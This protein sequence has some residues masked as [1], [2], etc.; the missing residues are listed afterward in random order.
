MSF[1]SSLDL[2]YPGKPPVVTLGQLKAFALEL[3][4]AMPVMHL[5]N[6]SLKYGRAI[7]KDLKPIQ[8]GTRNAAG[9]LY[10]EA[11][12]WNYEKESSHSSLEADAPFE[13]LWPPTEGSPDT[14]KL[15]SLGRWFSPKLSKHGLS[16]K[17]YRASLMLGDLTGAETLGAE[18]EK[19]KTCSIALYCLSLG[20]EPYAPGLLA[21]D[22]D[23]ADECLGMMCFSISGRGYFSWQPIARFAEQYQSHPIV[24]LYQDICRKHFPVPDIQDLTGITARLGERFLNRECYREG[25]WFLTLNE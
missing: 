8:I 12:K 6:V 3:Q 14:L 23:N 10:Y 1:W 9:F 13:S 21:D 5:R 15:G 2:F 17:I 20:I 4:Q 7:D 24:S 19:D 11:I 16:K 25:D 18:H 22:F